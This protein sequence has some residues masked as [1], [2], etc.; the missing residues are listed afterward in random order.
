MPLQES[1]FTGFSGQILHVLKSR[2]TNYSNMT[3][4]SHF[5]DNEKGCK[6]MFVKIFFTL[7][8]KNKDLIKIG[9]EIRIC[10][11]SYF[12]FISQVIAG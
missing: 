12:L 8:H 3:I 9:Q 2:Q 7:A 5:W 6:Q 11:S 4:F 1:S 10:Q